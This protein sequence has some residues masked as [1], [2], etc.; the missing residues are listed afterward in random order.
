MH[1]ITSAAGPELYKCRVLPCKVFRN[2]HSTAQV[3]H[4][5]D[6]LHN[7][8]I[9]YNSTVKMAVKLWIVFAFALFL[10]ISASASAQNALSEEIDLPSTERDTGSAMV[11]EDFLQT[12]VHKKH[13]KKYCCY[14]IKTR[15]WRMC[16]RRGNKLFCLKH[17]YYKDRRC[18]KPRKPCKWFSWT[19]RILLASE[20]HV[21]L[22]ECEGQE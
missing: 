19:K 21:V 12:S 4:F 5:E 16:R 11:V 9:L 20:A 2:R 3:L 6:H 18:Q 14:R 15:C 13:F 10:C 1:Q 8:G 22:D 17:K 7:Q